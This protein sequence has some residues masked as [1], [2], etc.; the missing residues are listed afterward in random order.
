MRC[1]TLVFYSMLLTDASTFVG[2]ENEEYPVE[3]WS[4]IFLSLVVVY[5]PGKKYIH[6]Y[7]IAVRTGSVISSFNYKKILQLF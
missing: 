3:P 2:G 7:F 4:V 5:R 1:Q 6:H